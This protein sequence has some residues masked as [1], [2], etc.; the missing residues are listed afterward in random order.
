[1]MCTSSTNL[2][3]THRTLLA[4][5]CVYTSAKA[6]YG[7][8]L[9][10][11]LAPA[12]M[13]SPCSDLGFLGNTV[14][15]KQKYPRWDQRCIYQRK[16]PRSSYFQHGCMIPFFQ[17]QHKNGSFSISKSNTNEIRQNWQISEVFDENEQNF[18]SNGNSR[19]FL[20]KLGNVTFCWFEIS[21]NFAWLS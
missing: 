19:K 2:Q 4:W 8:T 14:K 10:W 21:W 9:F 1:M 7:C 16:Q 18:I 5:R 11:Y 20:Q 15:N 13:I 6:W 12:G 3:S 17:P